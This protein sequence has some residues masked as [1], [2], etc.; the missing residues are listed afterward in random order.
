MKTAETKILM[1][2]AGGIGG[3]TAGNIAQA[4]YDIEIV[5]CYP[6]YAEK[7]EN[8]GLKIFGK[9]E[10]VT[11]RIPARSGIEKV[12]EQK[13]IIFLAT[14]VNSLNHIIKEI[15]HLLKNDSVIVSLQNGICEDALAAEYGKNRVI[16]CV[17]GWGATVHEPGVLEKT[18]KGEFIIGSLSGA[19][20]NHLHF[21]KKILSTTAPV[22]ITNN[23]LGHL[24]AKLIINSCITTMG[25]ICGMT[26]G[27]M[28]KNKKYRNIFL[29]IISEAVEVGD[30]AKIK[31]EKYAGK[32]DF[33]KLAY[34]YSR[35]AH[36]KS[37]LLIR[38]V[39]IKYRKLKSSSLQSLQTGRKSEVDFLNGY[40]AK[41]ARQ[42]KILTPL[43]DVLTGIIKE[44]EQGK[45]DITHKNFEIPFFNQF[46]Y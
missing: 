35:L 11:V 39:G 8:D 14:K 26:L 1:I 38:M 23:I 29:G 31:I 19:G 36:L 43:N 22:I 37:H 9:N 40:I 28:L 34:N 21:V 24:Y 30:A 17:V 4:G 46:S 7:I 42:H 13:D 16:G 20:S 3:I 15:G 44:I 10:N 2:G 6:G 41:K 25:A 45:R 33:N 5:D 12:T 27:D 18:S 32:L